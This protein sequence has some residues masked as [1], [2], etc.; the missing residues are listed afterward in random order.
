[1]EPGAISY[2]KQPVAFFPAGAPTN[3][4][5]QM[6]ADPASGN[7]VTVTN[8]TPWSGLGIPNGPGAACFRL[9]LG[10][11]TVT[12]ISAGYSFGFFIESDGSLRAM[13]ND[14]AGELGDGNSGS[15]TPRPEVIVGSNVVAVSAGTQHTLFLMSDGSLWAMGDNDFGELGD[16]TYIT[17]Y[18]PKQ[19]LASNVTAIAAGGYH[20]LFLKSDGSLWAMGD[21]E[22][23]Q[24]GDGTYNKASYPEQIV[25]SNVT[26]IAAGYYQSLFLK[27]DGS[28][29]GMGCNAAGELGDGTSSF[30]TRPEKVVDGNVTAIATGGFHSLF[31]KSD[32]SLWGMG[33]NYEGE[34]GDGSNITSYR[35]KQLVAGKVTAVSAGYIHSLFLKSD[36]SLWA[37]S[38]NKGDGGVN[39]GQLGDGTYN[40]CYHPE[41]I[42]AGNVTAIAAGG[43]FSLFSKS[44]GSLWGMGYNH[45]GELGDGTNT[46]TNRPERTVTVPSVPQPQLNLGTYGN[47]VVVLF[48]ALPASPIMGQTA[49]TYQLLMTTDLASGNWAPV[50]NGISFTGL[51]VAN[52]PSPVY[53]RLYYNP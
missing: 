39:A 12:R 4:V 10:A 28:L 19:I 32:G 26:A 22:Y 43:F 17:S 31:L 41:Q 29:W 24:L 5:L 40:N 16:G 33:N 27:S 37:M 30:V 3:F 50:P 46:T 34:L 49:I 14:S 38:S 20:S 15:L 8:A 45:E 2:G 7:W 25:A 42:V 1:M 23:G 18:R 52:A 13:G 53:F 48:P 9:N 35:P 6:S 11:Q 36:G 47:Q 21:N 51:Q 44:D